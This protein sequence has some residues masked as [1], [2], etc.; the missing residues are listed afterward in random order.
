MAERTPQQIQWEKDLEEFSI[1]YDIAN[2][3]LTLL[4]CHRLGPPGI[5]GIQGDLDAVCEDSLNDWKEVN[6]PESERTKP[7]GS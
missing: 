1:L 3:A 5:K 2:G 7:D 4:R 6:K